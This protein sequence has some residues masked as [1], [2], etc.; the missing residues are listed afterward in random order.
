MSKSLPSR[1]NLNHI[2]KEAKALLKAH[3][4]GNPGVCGTLRH[5][6]RLRDASDEE[7]LAASVSLQEVQHTL[8]CEYGLKSWKALVNLV[9]GDTEFATHVQEA[10]EVF[11]SKGPADDS[12]ESPW[13]QRRKEEWTKLLHTGDEGFRAMMKLARSDNGRA[14]NAAAVFFW[15]SDDK[16]AL[17]ELCT[18]L[19][20]PAATVRSRVALYYA[21][22]IH[23]AR[24][25]DRLWRLRETADTIP[26]GV[27]AILPLVCDDNVKVRMNAII[28]LSAYA[29]LGDARIV[30]ALRQALGDSHHKV[31]HA[32][33]RA[34]KVPCP[35][36]GGAS[37]AKEQQ[38][39]V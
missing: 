3:K 32:A 7:I 38:S 16:R 6:A 30:K 5:L 17:E 23:P 35:V 13:D 10:F 34:L 29:R 11:T 33:A 22:R 26:D 12:T 8:A 37:Q 19:G 36:C 28:V 15:L 14:R 9:A 21:S 39:T 2:K 24:A 1:P 31:Q 25:G 18:L 4:A 20:D 27:E